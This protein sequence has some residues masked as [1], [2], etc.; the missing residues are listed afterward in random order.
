MKIGLLLT[1]I[2]SGRDL[3]LIEFDSSGILILRAFK[4]GVHVNALH[5]VIR[6][7]EK[8]GLD[9]PIYKKYGDILK[10]K[11]WLPVEIL[12]KEAAFYADVLNKMFPPPC[13]D[14]RNYRASTVRYPR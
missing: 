11:Q 7:L 13:L 2:G 1:E 9:E 8:N 12:E 4:D 14:G 10:E 5:A 6:L 3:G